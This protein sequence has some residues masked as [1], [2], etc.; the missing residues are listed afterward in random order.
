MIF[1]ANDKIASISFGV[2]SVMLIKFLGFIAYHLQFI[3]YSESYSKH[4]PE[5]CQMILVIFLL[6]TEW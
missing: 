1:S 4:I 3:F 2:K 5:G 6:K